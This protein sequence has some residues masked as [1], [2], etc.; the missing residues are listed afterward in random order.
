MRKILVK[1]GIATLVLCVILAVIQ[2][3]ITLSK[4]RNEQR[5]R[6]TIFAPVRVRPSQHSR[7][8]KLSSDFITTEANSI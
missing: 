6:H 3:I 4:R 1:S 8:L 2:G 5:D 7:D